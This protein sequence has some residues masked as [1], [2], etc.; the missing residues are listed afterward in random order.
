MKAE[1]TP[2][3]K[4]MSSSLSSASVIMIYRVRRGLIT[5]DKRLF[6]TSDQALIAAKQY[7]NLATETTAAYQQLLDEV[8]YNT[9]L[10]ASK[11]QHGENTVEVYFD[12]EDAYD[13]IAEAE[14][15]MSAITSTTTT[16]DS[17]LLLLTKPS[18]RETMQRF[19][20]EIGA[21][22][23]IVSQVETEDGQWSGASILAIFE[24][25]N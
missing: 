18:R 15:R 5:L 21:A 4:A 20:V 25:D 19:G 10:I 8:K 2:K 17:K 16:S 22:R 1:T 24:M 14:A 9:E 6:Q 7:F 13:R 11:R 3:D 12:I 23:Y